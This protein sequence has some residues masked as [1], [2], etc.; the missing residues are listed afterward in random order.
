[1]PNQD[2]IIVFAAMSY[3]LD[4]HISHTQLALN[5]IAGILDLTTETGVLLPCPNPGLRCQDSVGI[6]IVSTG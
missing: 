1:M 4:L 6:P 5:Y 2:L 3:H